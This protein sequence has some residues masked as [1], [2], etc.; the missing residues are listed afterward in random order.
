MSKK[1]KTQWDAVKFF[2]TLSTFGEVPFLGSFRWIQK[3]VGQRTTFSGRE[4]SAMRN[5]VVVI[6]KMPPALFEALRRTVPATSELSLCDLVTDNARLAIQ[7]NS[8]IKNVTQDQ[9]YEL[10]L[11]AN[12]V[13]FWATSDF[14]TVWTDWVKCLSKNSEVVTQQVFDFAQA[15]A[16]L[17]AWGSL[18]DVVMGG[19]SQSTFF[20]K[21]QMPLNPPSLDVIG[22]PVQY[23]L[24]TGDVS[25][26]NSG[27]FSSVRTQN[28]EPPFNFAGW[29]G[30]RL[31]VKGDGQRYKFILRNSADWDS[32]GY[33]YAFDTEVGVW[34][35]VVVPFIELVPT[36]R[37]K[38]MPYAAPFDA[39]KAVSFQMMLSK[40]EYDRR[41]NPQF[42]PGLFELALARVDVYRERQGAP[43]VVVG[44]AQDEAVSARQQVAVSEL[45]VS[46]RWVE[47]AEDMQA[48][49]AAIS[50]ALA[51]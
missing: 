34:I 31:R 44:A 28:F 1:Q 6:G 14:S 38:S 47:P 8:A 37:A 51:T 2:T 22:E 18:D 7:T 32:L 19:I 41:L 27:G 3:M 42:T 50:A 35:D 21:K 24:F 43:L 15:G 33:I 20:L 12:T 39:S 4:L 48:T 13:V 16:D 36:F 45:E 25:T 40:F 46:Y 11:G 5:R 30:L 49:A 10:V 23:A 29:T 9:L 26:E 17:E